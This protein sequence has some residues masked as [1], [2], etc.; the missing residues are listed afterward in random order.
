MENANQFITKYIYLFAITSLV[1]PIFMMFSS[2]V[3]PKDPSNLFISFLIMNALFLLIPYLIKKRSTGLWEKILNILFIIIIPQGF[4]L[5]VLKP[6]GILEM[7][8][9]QIFCMG[10]Y[11]HSY[12]IYEK[13]EVNISLGAIL[14]GLWAIVIVGA[15]SSFMNVP[16]N[17]IN[18]YTT[19]SIIFLITSVYLSNRVNLENIISRRYRRKTSIS[20]SISFINMFLSIVFIV[21]LLFLFRFKGIAPYIVDLIVDII[22]FIFMV[23]KKI[24]EFLNSLLAPTKSATNSADG[25]SDFLKNMKSAK[26]SLLSQ[27][28]DII[29]YLLALGILGFLIFKTFGLLKNVISEI[30]RN[31][32]ILLEKATANIQ[33]VERGQNYTDVKTFIFTKRMSKV[34]AQKIKIKKINI[35]K[36]ADLNL[37]LRI[38]FKITMEYFYYKKNFNL[39]PTLTP[40][41]MGRLI[42]KGELVNGSII[43]E[44]VKEYNKVRYHKKYAIESTQQFEEFLK[45][46][47]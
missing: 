35:K 6:Y 14:A 20:T 37:R 17:I 24:V 5:I 23:I 1:F 10:L 45:N 18:Q 47:K 25:L 41:E 40:L 46:L 4:A 9:G 43:E 12:F 16:K 28:L 39:K 2:F 19:Y 36:I 31:F 8:I 34:K 7:F 3:M 30:I 42:T 33:M 32:L 11:I 38:I 29:G 21:I 44:L 13:E 26:K 15:L 22:R 27:I